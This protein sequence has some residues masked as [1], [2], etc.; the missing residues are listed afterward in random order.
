M[1]KAVVILLVIVAMWF[2]LRTHEPPE[3]TP[4]TKA[5]TEKRQ[6]E[7]AEREAASKAELADR[8][9]KFAAD[10]KNIIAKA[11]ALLAQRKLRELVDMDTEYA[12][13]HDAELNEITATGR[14]K[15]SEIAQAKAR[16]TRKREG[17]RI[18]MT[19]EEVIGSSWGRPDHINTTTTASGS[20]EQWVYD[21]YH[22]GYLYFQDG[23]LTAIQN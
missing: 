10:R 6:Q 16:V 2:G 17:V 11:K 9:A 4:A 20:H 13:M 1:W 21:R 3:P 19:K 18:G 14:D 23:V 8:K 7:T 22:N 15:L 12:V 5:E